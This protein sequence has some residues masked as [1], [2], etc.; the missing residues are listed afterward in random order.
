MSA[1]MFN[2]VRSLNSPDVFGHF[3]TKQGYAIN[4]TMEKS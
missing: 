1:L 4:V 2:S 3:I